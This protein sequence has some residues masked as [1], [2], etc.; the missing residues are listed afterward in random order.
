MNIYNPGRFQ[1]LSPNL[2]VDTANNKENIL[3]LAQMIKKLQYKNIITLFGTTQIDK[4]YARELADMIVAGERFIVDD[5]SE[6]SLPASE[7]AENKKKEHSVHLSEIDE[8]WLQ[9]LQSRKNTLIIIYGS[10]YLVGEI[11]RLSRYKPFA[12]A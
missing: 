6:R 9:A 7:Y 11:M 2:L 8:Q 4:K 10:F 1:W 3:F 12:T 5:F